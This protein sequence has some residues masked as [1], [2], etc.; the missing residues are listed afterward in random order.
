MNTEGASNV[1]R[2]SWKLLGGWCVLVV[3]WWVLSGGSDS[4]AVILVGALGALAIL[5]LYRRFELAVDIPLRSATY[6]LLWLKF[7]FI[8]LVQIGI[9]TARTCYL[10]LTGDIEPKIVAY[11]TKLERGSSR[12]FLLNSITLTPTTIAILSEKELVYIHHIS[13]GDKEDYDQMVDGIKSSFE[14]P[15]QKLIG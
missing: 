11:N 10:I 4:L 1:I 6:P 12:L 13:L 5:F 15:L 7:L 3:L 9:A 8:L 2:R 14:K